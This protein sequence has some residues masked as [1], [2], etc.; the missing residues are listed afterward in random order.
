MNGIAACLGTNT[1]TGNNPSTFGYG[2]HCWC[3]ITDVDNVKVSGAWVF[4]NTRASF[5]ECDRV[6]TL[7]C[8]SCI[9][10]GSSNSCTRNALFT[11]QWF[12]PIKWMELRRVWIQ[13]RR[14]EIIRVRLVLA[15][16]AGVKSLTWM[17]RLPEVLGRFKATPVRIWT[18][19]MFAHSIV[20]FASM[21]QMAPVRKM[22]FLPRSKAGPIKW[23]ELRRV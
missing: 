21:G 20:H 11:A 2:Q 14:V 18:A 9:F 7:I 5:E 17:V 3:K 8:S 12:G 13:I 16:I 23:M 10:P 19:T 22:P 1:K 15:G 6:C 4:D